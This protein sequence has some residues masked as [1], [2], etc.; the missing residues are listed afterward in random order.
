MSLNL[1]QNCLSLFVTSDECLSYIRNDVCGKY[2]TRNQ[3]S[4]SC[5]GRVCRF[6][7]TV[8]LIGDC[9]LSTIVIVNGSFFIGHPCDCL[10][11]SSGCTPP[12]RQCQLGLG[13]SCPATLQ[14]VKRYNKL[15]GGWMD[16]TSYPFELFTKLQMLAVIQRAGA[17][18]KIS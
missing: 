1:L 8:S 18:G 9:K 7:S 16:P 11:T 14:Q 12:H 10:A 17:R 5:A 2:D 15:V 4:L 3:F 6:P 13:F